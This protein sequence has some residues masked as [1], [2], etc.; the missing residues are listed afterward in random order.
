MSGTQPL[1]HGADEEGDDRE[2]A[3]G[4]GVF[5]GGEAQLAVGVQ[6]EDVDGERGE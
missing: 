5:V 2:D 1:V 3:K 6:E 4:H